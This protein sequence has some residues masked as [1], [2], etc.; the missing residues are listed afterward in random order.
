MNLLL[1]DDEYY[2]V[3]G[4]HA[5]IDSMQLGF[6][7]IYCA[8]NM[9]HAQ[10][11]YQLYKIDIMISD[12]EMPKGSGLDL[13]KW[14]RDHGYPTVTI[15][16]TSFANFNYASHAIKLQSIDY[17][18]KP[19]DH[20]QLYECMLTA[21][22]KVR[23]AEVQ[24]LYKEKSKF[25][26][27]SKKKLEEQFWSD[28]CMQIIPAK[29]E[30]ISKELEQ[31]HLSQTLLNQRFF[32]ALL[33]AYF[34]SEEGQWEINLYE[35]A[36]KNVISEILENADIHPIVARI[37]E[38][39]YLLI[40]PLDDILDQAKYK[41]ICN[42]IIRTLTMS[43]PGLF[44]L[45]IDLE[46][47]LL[48]SDSS[49]KRLHHFA[50]NNISEE[51]KV[52]DITVP[53]ADKYYTNIAFMNTWPNM[54][55]QHKKTEVKEQA[56]HFLTDLQK[57]TMANRSDLVRFNHDFMQIIYSILEKNGES[58]HG[59]FDNSTSE[60]I[61]DQ[62]CNSVEAMKIW[63]SHAIDVFDDCLLAINHSDSSID[64][65]KKFIRE[66]L[67]D[68]LNRRKLAALVFL[69][70]D[71][72][73]HVFSERTGESLTSFILNERIKKAKELLLLSQ[74]SIRDIALISGFPN[75]SYFSRQFKSLTGKTPQEYRRNQN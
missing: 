22:N 47:S 35:F 38:K 55:M 1:V 14:V 57:S 70:P 15:F 42:Q 58:A 11:F 33:Q 51:C 49:F 64:L 26:D 32:I 27:N 62:A 45:Y 4:L 34:K 40:L 29:I 59:L 72:L 30:Q 16:L 60:Q 6:E 73:S 21:I 69:S 2:S 7:H 18:L 25:W 52:I 19:I 8:Y 5:S 48:N 66:N 37:S 63:I 65:I 31:Y 75:I 68:D 9:Q 50:R 23:H 39:Q 10:E 61:F 54:L 71:Y 36:I 43:L 20:N 41:I 24:E 56:L 44:Q 67:D 53:L 46:T 74:K 13:L 3:E 17:L 28:L 12:I